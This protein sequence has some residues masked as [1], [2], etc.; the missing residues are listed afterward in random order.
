VLV[1][2]DRFVS[3]FVPRA[4]QRQHLSCLK[5]FEVLK[6]LNQQNQ[7]IFIW[8]FFLLLSAI[9]EVWLSL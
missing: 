7:N 1:N 2:N 4:Q 3:R 9:D 8:I 6:E 5:G